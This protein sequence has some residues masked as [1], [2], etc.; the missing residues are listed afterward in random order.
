MNEDYMRIIRM[1]IYKNEDHNGIV[2]N[3][4]SLTGGHWFEEYSHYMF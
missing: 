2:M 1:K 3:C 4:Y